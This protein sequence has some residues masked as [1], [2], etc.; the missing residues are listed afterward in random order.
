MV[1]EHSGIEGRGVFARRVFERGETIVPYAPKLRRLDRSDPE[2]AALS[3]TK[4]TLL[5][6]DGSVLVPDTEMPGGWLCNHSCDPNADL[7][8]SGDG[9]IQCRRRIAPGQE[10]T[11]FYGWVTENQPERDPC[12][13]GTARCR[14]AI[15]FDVSDADA[16]CFEAD[17]EAGERVRQRLDAY[18]EFLAPIEQEHVLATV[19]DRLRRL[20]A[21]RP[22]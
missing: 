7:Y 18:R 3:A 12:R 20:A 14:G 19:I 9:R 17:T 15:N 2:A 4:L 8:A 22:R 6:N 10:I 16:A 13:C 11:I 21:R 1:Y 5:T